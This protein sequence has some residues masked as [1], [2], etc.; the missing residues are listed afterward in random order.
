MVKRSLSRASALLLGA[1][2]FLAASAPALGEGSSPASLPVEAATSLFSVDMGGKDAELLV[3]GSWEASLMG[4]TGLVLDNSG[5]L[6]LSDELPVLF[7]QT[8]D[9]YLSF[10]LLKKYFVEARVTSDASEVRYSAGYKGGEGELIKEIRVGNDGISF[11]A[12]PF[13][14]LGTGSYRS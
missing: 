1:A 9:L 6:S 2:L 11:P 3:H 8:P 10:L 7:T 5:G 13:L 4:Q 14:S 12:L